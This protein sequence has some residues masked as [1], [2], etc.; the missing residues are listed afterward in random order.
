LTADAMT[1]LEAAEV[2][3]AALVAGT[4]GQVLLARVHDDIVATGCLGV[5]TRPPAPTRVNHALWRTE[6]AIEE[7]L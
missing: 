2:E 1:T 7:D 5:F 6:F 4:T 3:Q